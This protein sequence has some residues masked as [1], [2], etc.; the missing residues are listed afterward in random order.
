VTAVVVLVRRP[1][2][3]PDGA[4]AP[5]L[6]GRCDE[7]A[8]RA[9]LALGAHVAVVAAGPAE[10]EDDALR[11]ALAWGAARALRVWDPALEGLD[12]HATAQVLA[13]AARR[14]GFDLVL[15]GDRSDDEGDGAVGP[16]VAE[17]LAVPH[18][19][20]ALDV[21]L[22]GAGALVVRRDPPHVRTLRVP[23]PAL[24]TVTSSRASQPVPV[25]GG[26]GV[27]TLDLD[28]LGIRAAELRPRQ[29]CVGRATEAPPPAPKLLGRPDELYARLRQDRLL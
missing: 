1:R 25:A 3:A 8:L 10:R 12:Y 18:V 29:Q 7:A 28:A 15:G 27:E 4:A 6:L 9:A 17:A 16:A 22:D 24:V 5:R 19:T 14:L 26:R 23:L 2:A 21:A 11:L 20:S 13:A